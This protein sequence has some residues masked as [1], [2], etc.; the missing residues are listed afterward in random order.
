MCIAV[1]LVM[2][3]CVI[4]AFTSCIFC[5]FNK[6]QKEDIEIQLHPSVIP[7][8]QLNCRRCTPEYVLMHLNFHQGYSRPRADQPTEIPE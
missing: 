6:G 7:L 8:H 2:L 1:G 3:P 4:S 5:P